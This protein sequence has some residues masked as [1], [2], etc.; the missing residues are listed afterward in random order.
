MKIQ[1]DWLK[2]TFHSVNLYL[3]CH[4]VSSVL[5][6]KSSSQYLQLGPY[7]EYINYLD[8][9]KVQIVDDINYMDITNVYMSNDDL[10]K[11]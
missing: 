6:T 11:V 8:L 2:F 9:A 3:T 4:H 10:T 7:M 1:S 5:G